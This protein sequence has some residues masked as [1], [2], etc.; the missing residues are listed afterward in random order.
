[1]DPLL[2]SNLLLWLVVII[3]GALVAALTRQVGV[4]HERINPVGAMM[5]T[6]SLS[7]GQPAPKHQLL[8][9]Q[10]DSIS[11][12]DPADQKTLL[13][14]LSPTCPVCDTLLPTILRVAREARPPLRVILASDGDEAEHRRFMEQHALGSVPYALSA[15]LG[16][17]FQV[18]KLPYA[19][20]IDE[21]GTLRAM[22]LVNT[23]EH[24]ESLLE[25]DRLGVGSIQELMARETQTLEVHGGGNA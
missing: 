4:L 24:V 5:P 11:I 17:S 6:Q 2:A 19:V 7:V 13:F 8:T 20:L 23:R 25:A 12:G 15:T 14:F 22:G 21:T 1:M 10:G 16:I 3:L 18:A 9:L